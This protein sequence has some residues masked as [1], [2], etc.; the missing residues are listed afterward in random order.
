MTFINVLYYYLVNTHASNL[1]PKLSY[2]TLQF[3]L[4]QM[5][6]IS[7]SHRHLDLD[8]TVFNIEL[9]RASSYTTMYTMY[10]FHVPKSILFFSYHAKAGIDRQT[11]THTQ[12]L[13][14]ILYSCVLQK[15]TTKSLVVWHR[16]LRSV[17]TPDLIFIFVTSPGLLFILFKFS[18]L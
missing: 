8:L 2:R 1:A 15:A 13:R 11:D 17:N 5:G 7:N 16:L 14:G 6:K 4:G 3:V 12:R 10:K 18:W 9:V